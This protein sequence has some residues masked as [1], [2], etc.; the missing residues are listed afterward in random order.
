MEQRKYLEVP[1]LINILIFVTYVGP[2][3]PLAFTFNDGIPNVTMVDVVPVFHFEID[4]L[5]L[6]SHRKLRMDGVS[7]VDY[8]L[9]V[10]KFPKVKNTGANTQ[11]AC[12]KEI[13]RM[14][15]RI[16]DLKLKDGHSDLQNFSLQFRE[17]SIINLSNNVKCL[18]ISWFCFRREKTS[19]T[20]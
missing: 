17:Q 16:N 12:A 14:Q 18:H 2:S 20:K 3:L 6:K 19:R 11:K 1:F 7:K 10:P 13:R 4:V 5:Q 8:F 9:I 15:N